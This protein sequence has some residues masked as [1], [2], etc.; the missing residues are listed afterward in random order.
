MASAFSRS[1]L[2]PVVGFEPTTARLRIE[3]STAEL[4]RQTLV[5][6]AA[7]THVVKSRR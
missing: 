3:C 2:E 4:H 6:L 7:T 5:I 1:G